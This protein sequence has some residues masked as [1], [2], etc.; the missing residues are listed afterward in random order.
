M[1]S[2]HRKRM[3]SK[4]MKDGID[5]FEDHE[6]LEFL[7]YWAIP[8]KDTNTIA[9]SLINK[10]GS[11][12]S[13]FDAPY[14]FLLEVNGVGE[15]VAIFLKLIPQIARIY[16]ENKYMINK[17]IPSME[18]CCQKLVL[19]FIGRNE[20]AVALMLFDSKGKIVFDGIINKGSVNA[21]EIYSRRI[22]ELI[23][24]YFATSLLLAHNH[25]SGVAIPSKDDIRSTEK[26]SRILESMHV[27]FLDHIIVADNDYV[28]MMQDHLSSVFGGDEWI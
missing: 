15:N 10:F 12:S 2:N 23:S 19:K 9:H 4:F 18:E 28:S 16:E 27:H 8:R 7:L 22:V 6:V 1:H 13:V 25:P 26:L 14:K 11:I 3:K 20:E 24:S 17:P 5:I 21:V